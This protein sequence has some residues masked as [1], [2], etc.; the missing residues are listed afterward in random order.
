MPDSPVP[1]SPVPDSPVPNAIPETFRISMDRA[2]EN[3]RRS[4]TRTNIL[5]SG[6]TISPTNSPDN[7]ISQETAI[8][9]ANIVIDENVTDT[10]GENEPTREEATNTT[11]LTTSHEPSISSDEE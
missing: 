4:T 5:V 9:I 8:H 1:D 7:S 6:G 11:P 3:L 10:Q 2:L